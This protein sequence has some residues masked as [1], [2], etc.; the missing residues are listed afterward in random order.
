MTAQTR[1]LLQERQERRDGARTGARRRPAGD[2]QLAAGDEVPLVARHGARAPPVALAAPPPADGPLASSRAR[3]QRRQFRAGSSFPR[4]GAG[5]VEHRCSMLD[6]RCSMLDAAWR[7]ASSDPHRASSVERRASAPLPPSTRPPP[8][9]LGCGPAAAAGWPGKGVPGHA[10]QELLRFE[11]RRLMHRGRPYAPLDA[12][13]R[14]TTKRPAAHPPP[15][16][17]AAAGPSRRLRN[18]RRRSCRQDIRSGWPAWPLSAALS[19]IAEDSSFTPKGTLVARVTVTSRVK[20]TNASYRMDA[21]TAPAAHRRAA[22]VETSSVVCRPGG[23]G[24]GAP[25]TA[26]GL[27]G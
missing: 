15:D 22:A 9:R 21:A 2:V 5:R 6:A 17:A 7:V 1:G 14:S 16:P 12:G 10:A 13:S 3:R 23:T 25:P 8:R 18:C 19:V 27:P 24:P 26:T 4:P 11:M 20:S